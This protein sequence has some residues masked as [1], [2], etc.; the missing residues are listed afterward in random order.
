M[1]GRLFTSLRKSTLDW[2]RARIRSW[3][4]RSNGQLWWDPKAAQEAALRAEREREAAEK[5]QRDA[6]LQK[7]DAEREAAA[8][9]AEAE[10]VAEAAATETATIEGVAGSVAGV[11]GDVASTG[12]AVAPLNQP[13]WRIAERPVWHPTVI[14]QASSVAHAFPV[15]RPVKRHGVGHAVPP[16]AGVAVAGVGVAAAGAVALSRVINP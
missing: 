9:K 1:S 4:D 14:W 13:E 6:A 7:V 15:D 5:A 16:L 8:L 12:N 10:R 2:E 11:A 3:M